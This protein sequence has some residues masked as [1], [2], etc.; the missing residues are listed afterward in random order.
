MKSFHDNQGV[1]S[2]SYTTLIQMTLVFWNS[3]FTLLPSMALNFPIIYLL[4][5]TDSGTVK[6]IHHIQLQIISFTKNVFLTKKGKWNYA[7]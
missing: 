5:G 4:S 6:L 1:K 3:V 7:K 2:L